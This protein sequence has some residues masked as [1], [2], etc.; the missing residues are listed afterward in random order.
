MRPVPSLTTVNY[1]ADCMTIVGVPSYFTVCV[2]QEKYW[3]CVL[4]SSCSHG[5][6]NR[7]NS[8]I[9]E[10]EALLSVTLCG[11]AATGSVCVYVCVWLGCVFIATSQQNWRLFVTSQRHNF[12]GVGGIKSACR[13]E[14][15]LNFY[16]ISSWSGYVIQNQQRTITD[17]LAWSH[18]GTNHLSCPWCSC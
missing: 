2:Q 10:Q 1:V 4:H 8:L 12:A 15:F 11:S 3:K 7:L 18:V 5:D 9:K 17:Y 6:D 13:D 16:F 14:P